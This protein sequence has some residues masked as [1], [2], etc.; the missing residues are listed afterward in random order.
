[1]LDAPRGLLAQ[2]VL[3][4]VGAILVVTLSLAFAALLPPPLVNGWVGLGLTAAVPT[5]IVQTTVWIS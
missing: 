4:V 5:L 2:P 1:M 3:G